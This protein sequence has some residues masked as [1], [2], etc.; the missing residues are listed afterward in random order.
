MQHVRRMVDQVDLF[1]APARYLRDRYRDEFGIPGDRLEYLD[2]GFDVPR[3]A[4][5]KRVDGKGFT[6]GY[7]G[8]HIP[9]KGIHHLVEAAGR[10]RGDCQLRIWG[11]DRGQATQALGEHARRV[12]ARGGPRIEWR[13]EYR[14]QDI[15]R[16]VFDHVDAIVVPSVWVENSPLVIHEAQQAR[17][18]VITARAGGM[19]EYVHHEVNGLLFEHRQPASLASQMQRLVDDPGLAA[20]LGQRGYLYTESGDVPDVAGHV[21][22]VEA[23]YR[24][25]TPRRGRPVLPANGG[26]WRVTFDTNPDD[27]NL[28]CLMCEEHS[29]LKGRN[30]DGEAQDRSLRRM[31]FELIERVVGE[32]AGNGL[33]EVIPSTMG[34]PLLYRHMDGLI[35]LCLHHGV[36]LNLTT[37]GTF[38]GRGAR[39]WAG[40][41][42]PVASDV[43]IS[44]NGASAG[45]QERIMPGSPWPQRLADLETFLEV[46]DRHARDGGHRCT[47]TLQATFMEHNVE[48]L[49]DIVKLAARRGIDRV[50]G[51]HVW[52][53]Y[54]ELEAVSMR[55]NPEAIARWNRV[56][57]EARW[58]CREHP[59]PDGGQ[60]RLE[61][62]DLLDDGATEDLTPGGACPF[63]GR[64]AWINTEGRFDPC[65]A[66]DDL[67]RTLGSFGTVDG[68]GFMALWNGVSYRELLRTYRE[69]PLCV[70]CNMRTRREVTP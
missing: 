26:P 25:L 12:E 7:I 19:A 21:E 10:L 43:K 57:E 15:V 47:V 39:A 63:L 53:H 6:F 60:V 16:D 9:A 40:R 14:N 58:V 67:R 55:R 46:R 64:E 31:P 13:P 36:R 18:P 54:P 24:R 41:I 20:R 35:D 65:C 27:C 17:V 8:T 29:P 48:D 50:K 59:L 28:G 4:G 69:H 11:R 3:L 68:V 22:Q 61:N 33:E 23:I 51:H 38:P 5:R 32:L 56:V 45:T 34:E 30:A 1:I 49:P 52:T 62:F 44:W 70:A 42:V 2:Y 66:P 37:N